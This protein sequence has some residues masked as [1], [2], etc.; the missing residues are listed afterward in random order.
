MRLLH[1]TLKDLSQILRDRRSLLFLVAMPIFFTLFMGFA[2]R[3]SS[4]PT[5]KRLVLGWINADPQGIAANQLIDSL[6]KL[7]DLRLEKIDPDD[8][9]N[10]IEKVRKGELAGILSIPPNFSSAA[11]SGG[12]PQVELYTDELTTSGQSVFQLVRGPIT[13]VMGAVE[14]ANLITKY[15]ITQNILLLG[16][17]TTN[18]VKSGFDLASQ[19][20]NRFAEE[21]IQ[22]VVEKGIQPVEGLPFGGNP[23][24]QTSP[25]ILTMFALFGLV[26]SANI[27][28][29]ERKTHT[30][31]R[32]MTT[33]MSAAEIIAGHL[34]AN[35]IMCFGSDID[36]THLWAVG[37]G[38]R[39][40]SP[41]SCDPG[42][43]DCARPL[44]RSGWA[45]HQCLR[46]ERLPG[47]R[48]FPY[49]HV[50]LLGLRRNLVSPGRLWRSVCRRWATYP[51][52]LGHDRIPEHLDAW[53]GSVICLAAGRNFTGI[54]RGLLPDRRLAL[55][56]PRPGLG[57][58]WVF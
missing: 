41:T 4:T 55:F 54:R 6:G 20:W 22:V 42:H 7:S 52:C 34:L 15:L 49:H 10:S 51:H 53:T 24:N 14:I 45:N 1:L 21:G 33:S 40:H 8:L 16:S 47:C 23:N 32:M 29:Q 3:S 58:V 35:F 12:N 28:V 27:L 2:Y 25:G 39:L 13:R 9:D 30:L 44:G 17:D 26:S 56:S 57:I 43:L 36:V 5:D 48:I 11:M 38:C 50:Y 19:T 31:Q 46:R 18:E 37:I